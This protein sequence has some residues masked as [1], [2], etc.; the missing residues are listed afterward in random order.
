[1]VIKS[2]KERFVTGKIVNNK[3]ECLNQ[4]DI[5]TC[6]K[7]RFRLDENIKSRSN[8]EN[9]ERLKKP[10]SESEDEEKKSTKPQSAEPVI[11]NKIKTLI[12]K[13]VEKQIESEDE[14]IDEDDLPFQ[15]K[16]VVKKVV[17]KVDQ[18]EIELNSDSDTDKEIADLDE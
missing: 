3:V 16:K 6:K 18:K 13:V 5:E 2:A 10:E 15:N 12:T 11:H 17:K 1:M 8:S 7:W 9:E 4:E 14:L